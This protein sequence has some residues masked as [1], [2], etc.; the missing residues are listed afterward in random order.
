[1]FGI[2]QARLVAGIAKLQ[3]ENCSY[4]TPEHKSDRCDCKYGI[5]EEGR[6]L[7][8]EVCGCPELRQAEE[9]LRSLTPLEFW[10]LCKR[11]RIDVFGLEKPKATKK[12]KGR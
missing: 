6:A 7:G 5:G 1:M 4:S 8:G 12:R 11:A 10:R 9:L 3:H 2:V